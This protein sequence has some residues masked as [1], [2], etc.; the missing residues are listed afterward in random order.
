M[1]TQFSWALE[2]YGIVLRLSETTKRHF[3][4]DIETEVLA[5]K[6]VD[7]CPFALAALT[8]LEIAVL[9]GEAGISVL[10]DKS[11]YQMSHAFLAS[12]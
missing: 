5:D 11:A 7:M 10:A 12:L 4:S 2:G 9:D 8:R 3:R 6:W 1:S